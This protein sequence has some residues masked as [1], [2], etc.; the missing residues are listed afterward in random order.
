MSDSEDKPKKKK[1]KRPAKTFSDSDMS[2]EFVPKKKGAKVPFF[3]SD[4]DS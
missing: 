3:V 2:D 1:T 4:N